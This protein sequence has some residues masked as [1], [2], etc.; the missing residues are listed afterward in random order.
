MKARMVSSSSS[1]RSAWSRSAEAVAVSLSV[2]VSRGSEAKSTQN[3]E[4]SLRL[5][6]FGRATSRNPDLA[7]KP[8]LCRVTLLGYFLWRGDEGMPVDKEREE[9]EG[10]LWTQRL[11]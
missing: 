5:S 10:S 4:A 3:S 2:S 6:K 8:A 9:E 11:A 7:T 1:G